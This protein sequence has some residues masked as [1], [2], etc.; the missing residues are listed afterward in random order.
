MEY[1]VITNIDDIKKALDIFGIP[2]GNVGD[3]G[4]YVHTNTMFEKMGLGKPA[5][6]SHYT[7][8]QYTGLILGTVYYVDEIKEHI[9]DAARE[10]EENAIPAID[11][12]D[13]HTTY[14]I[15]RAVMSRLKGLVKGD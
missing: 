13:K 12:Y 7:P 2:Y 14:Q 11:N 9:Y 4:D 8:I 6:D 5:P 10:L 3:D 1:R 15:I